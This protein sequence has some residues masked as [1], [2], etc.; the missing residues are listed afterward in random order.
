MIFFYLLLL[1]ILPNSFEE[2]ITL[3]NLKWKNR[4]V[5][6]FPDS[7]QRENLDFD[8]LKE[9]LRDR[10]LI[11]FIFNEDGILSNSDFT[12]SAEQQKSITS[13]YQM[14]STKNCWVLIGLDG[15]VK[16]KKEG[17]LDW[18]FIFRT[19]DSMPMRRSERG[20]GVG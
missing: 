12:F 11:Y 5:L 13:K 8:F 14:G 6:F 7:S 1:A 9:E 15:G 19:V 20:R 17:D 18:D 3:D 4:V 2:E 16:V 10:K